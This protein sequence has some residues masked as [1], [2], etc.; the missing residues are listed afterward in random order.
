MKFSTKILLILLSL[1]LLC[2]SKGSESGDP[3]SES[4]YELA[5]SPL[6]LNFNKN[7][8]TETVSITS[9]YIRS[10]SSNTSWCHITPSN[11]QGNASI[12]INTDKNNEPSQST[13]T[14]STERCSR[15][16]LSILK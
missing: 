16:L 10:A 8:G 5:A 11:G 1:W 7:G 6:S 3:V 12:S 15:R 9:N 2:C 4:K 13:A 14:V